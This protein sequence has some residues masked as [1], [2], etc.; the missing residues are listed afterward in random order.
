MFD[1]SGETYVEEEDKENEFGVTESAPAIV[2]GVHE[3]GDAL[4]AIKDEAEDEN[5]ESSFLDSNVD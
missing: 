5:G 3:A 4:F 2:D 1:V